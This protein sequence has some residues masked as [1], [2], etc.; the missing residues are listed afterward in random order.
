MGLS[1]EMV[2]NTNPCISYNMEENTTCLMLL[3]MAHAAYGHNAFFKNNYLF[4]MWTAPDA[5]VDYMNFA[6]KYIE[7]CETKYGYHEVEDTLDACHALQSY[8]VDKYMHPPKL[9]FQKEMERR[10]KMASDDYKFV[11]DLWRTLPEKEKSDKASDI[12]RFPSQPQENMLYFI[13]KNAPYLEPWQREL[14]RIVRKIA[15]YFYPQGQTKVSNEGFASYSHY[16]IINKMYDEGYLSDG[17]MLEFIEHH[18]S[19]LAQPGVDSKYYYGFNPYT[20]GFN[21]YADIERICTNPTDEDREWFPNL[22]GK[23]WLT[24]VHYAME[25]FKDESFI[26]QY[27][28]PKVMRDMRMLS[29]VDDSDEP[30]WVVNSIH[31]KRGYKNIRE[32][33]A[34]QYQRDR[35]IPD[36][37]VDKVDIYGDRALTLTYTSVDS[38]NIEDSSA[39]LT[40][41]YAKLLWGCP[42]ELVHVYPD[43]D[44]ETQYR[45]DE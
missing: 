10:K 3:V 28:S 33:L 36:I 31:N 19:V 38:K 2:L 8:G 6:K 42:V 17:F 30:V 16:K 39:S 14:V 24:E 11:N 32:T 37:Q 13:E 27:L 34:K 4:K 9:S 18:T 20:L 22:I 45:T 29:I 5:I 15:Q 35:Y 7:E 23:D 44:R 43:G 12:K 21:I 26:L 41:E 25:N 1:Y 40:C